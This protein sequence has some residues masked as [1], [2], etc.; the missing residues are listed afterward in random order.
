M[1]AWLILI[2]FWYLCIMLASGFNML[3]YRL[4]LSKS[5]K[6]KFSFDNCFCEHCGKQIN[7][8]RLAN[9]PIINYILLNG[10]T[11]CCNQQINILHPISEFYGG[12]LI[13]ILIM[14]A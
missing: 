10:K 14:V 11:N 4:T 3:I 1:L 6:L 9:L 5:D 13:F 2:P 12:T 8:K 7:P